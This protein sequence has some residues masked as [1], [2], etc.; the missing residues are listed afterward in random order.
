[1]KISTSQK[2][3]TV[4]LLIVF[5]FNG[6]AQKGWF[7][8]EDKKNQLFLYWGYNRALF[9]KSDISFKGDNYDFTLTDV[10]ANDRPTDFAVDPYLNPVAFTI[11]QYN[12]RI[13]YYFKSR[14]SASLGMD[15]MKYVMPQDQN[16]KING[17]IKDELTEIEYIF[18][19]DDIILTD[20]FLTFEHTDGLN[21]LS[22]EVEHFSNLY[23][24]NQKHGINIY[25][26]AGGGMLIPKSNVKLMGYE[27]HD[28]FHVAG[29]GL[30]AK[31]GINVTVWRFFFI[32]TEIKGGYINMNNILVRPGDVADRSSQD[33]WFTQWNF[34]LG[35]YIP[36]SKNKK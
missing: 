4:S 19:D 1:V 23:R 16:V 10:A 36:L 12:Y 8:Q 30:S 33:F 22:L 14:W 35:G 29:F 9:S 28:A 34:V 25:G 3:L 21:Y 27:R 7:E 15:H 13:G 20:S 17:R 6:F 24:F 32:Q 18:N 5:S 11:P 26:G 31:A 2:W